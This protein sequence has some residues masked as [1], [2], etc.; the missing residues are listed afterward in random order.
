MNIHQI[1]AIVMPSS[2]EPSSS[3]PLL[4]ILNGEI[5]LKQTLISIKKWRKSLPISI[6]I[7]IGDNTSGIE[8]LRIAVEKMGLE[9]IQIYAVM[10][11]PE[12][13][14]RVGGAGLSECNSILSIISSAK[15]KSNDII[16]KSNSRYFI[17]NWKLIVQRLP[18]SF[19]LAVWPGGNL[20][21][22]ET[23]FY[24][25]RV[26]N[27]TTGLPKI[28]REINEE[29]GVFVEHLYPSMIENIKSDMALFQ[30]PPAIRG[31]RGHT[32]RKED[33][34]SEAYAIYSAVRIRN[35]TK[36]ILKVRFAK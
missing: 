6:P 16:M 22:V 30:F 18:D 9:N 36:K 20:N 34:K 23:G 35:L 1:D 14:F 21:Y 25:S 33:R 11:I 29:E 27:L 10:P 15:L 19:Q 5:R 4:S 12:V 26:G 32:G 31:V 3:T 7:L 17:F 8:K 24:L 28:M 2:V 13:D